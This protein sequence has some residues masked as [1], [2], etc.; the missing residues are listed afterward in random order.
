MSF[1]ILL[2]SLALLAGFI[3]Y[4]A[5]FKSEQARIKGLPEVPGYPIVGN[6]V[7]LG[8]EHALQCK[9]WAE[10]YGPVFQLRFGNK[11]VVVANSYKAVKELWI[12]N[13]S[14]TISRPMF[15]TF[16]SVVSSSQGFTIG[17]S[18]WVKMIHWNH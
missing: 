13:Q 6:L 9:Q 10:K 12:D 2:V 1:S 18:P 15:H 17:T 8:S 5:F 4:N 14:A 16:H 3:L 7:Q 11:R